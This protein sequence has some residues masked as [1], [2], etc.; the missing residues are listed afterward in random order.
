VLDV[1]NAVMSAS[2]IKE[3][4]G[5]VG[6]LCERVLDADVLAGDQRAADRGGVQDIG[7]ADKDEVN[8]R[9]GQHLLEV[10]HDRHL[11]L[12]LLL[13][14]SRVGGRRRAADN[15]GERDVRIVRKGLFASPPCPPIPDNGRSQ[16]DVYVCACACVRVCGR[17]G[18]ATPPQQRLC[19][20]SMLNW[21]GVRAL[22]L[23]EHC[24]DAV[25][26]C[27]CV[28]VCVWLD[29]V[30][31]WQAHCERLGDMERTVVAAVAA[32]AAGAL[33]YGW[34]QQR[35]E[36]R[37]QRRTQKGS[38]VEVSGLFVYPIK[39]CRGFAVT[40]SVLDAYGLRYDRRWLVVDEKGGC[41]CSRATKT[42]K[43][44]W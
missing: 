31:G 4:A 28:C 23:Y 15:T 44:A 33:L 42:P 39:S 1:E 16:H 13:G 27:V 25:C 35:R 2:K 20:S 40:Q 37:E 6:R 9:I 38:G 10:R 30:C 3:S 12:L 5:I 26:V 19:A 22:A 17:V 18:T 36:A 7:R 29:G 43:M 32:V 41:G 8:V 21:F 24:S 11:L 34:L 14:Q